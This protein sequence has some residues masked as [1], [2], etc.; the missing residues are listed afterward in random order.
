[1]HPDRLADIQMLS[2][3]QPFVMDNDK[4]YCEKCIDLLDAQAAPV[5]PNCKICGKVIP[6]HVTKA[7]GFTFHEACLK[8][9]V[10]KKPLGDSG[11]HDDTLGRFL[12]LDCLED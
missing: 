7:F 6:V 2:F 8:C 10:C 5:H 11:F 3:W 12:H 9:A 4:M 1:M